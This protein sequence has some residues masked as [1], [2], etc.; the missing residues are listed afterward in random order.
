MAEKTLQSRVLMK[1]DTAENWAKGTNFSPKKGEVIVYNGNPPRIKVGDG[2]TNVNNLPFITYP[3]TQEQSDKLGT[4]EEG[5][6]KYILP[7]AS[8]T[9]GGVKTTSTVSSTSGLTATPIINGV[10][11]Y[12]DTTYTLSGL[13][14]VPTSRKI[15]GKAL[16]A[17]ITLSASDVGAAAKSDAEANASDITA[18]TTRVTTAESQILQKADSITLSVLETKVDGISVGGTNLLTQA[19]C[20]A[21][22]YYSESAAWRSKYGVILPANISNPVFQTSNL[23]GNGAFVVGET[24]TLSFTAKAEGTTNV[25]TDLYPDTI[26]GIFGNAKREVTTTPRKIVMTD[27]LTSSDNLG[28]VYLRFWRM[29]SEPK[30]AIQIWDIKLEKGNKA[31]DWSPAPEDLATADSLA[32]YLPLSGGTMTGVINVKTGTR[33][34][35]FHFAPSYDSSYAGTI[36]YDAGDN[37]KYGSSTSFYVRQYSV[38]TGSTSSYEASKFEDFRFPSTASGLTTSMNYTI[39]TT[40]NPPTASQVGALPLS[41]GTLTGTLTATALYASNG[42]VTG[43]HLVT[44]TNNYPEVYFKNAAGTTLADFYADTTTGAYS[45]IKLRVYADTDVKND[46]IFGTSGLFYAPILQGGSIYSSSNV[47]IQKQKA[48]ENY[49]FIGNTDDSTNIYMVINAQERGVYSRNSDG[50]REGYVFYSPNTTTDWIFN[51][52]AKS[53]TD[54]LPISLGGTGA[55]TAAGARTNLGIT[56]ANIGAAASSHT[57]SYLPLSGGTISGSL[58]VSGNITSNGYSV[59]TAG[60][61]VIYSST[62]PTGSAGMIWL[63]P[64]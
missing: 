48:N 39:F 36:V 53:L 22:E 5:A 31:T 8:S 12:K 17:D 7:T 29:P 58:A 57:H 44:K 50:T 28:D 64:V 26:G 56:P 35:E 19:S 52:K 6:N 37:N 38:T 60:G 9:L 30:F 3:F 18:L 62:Q 54:T 45:D 34:S 10:P 4:I 40:K 21:N 24:Y 32:K 59:Y 46:F 2:S 1:N 11:Y 55:T 33:Y 47:I 16:S 23:N 25:Y 27:V 41:G 49:V 51:G 61:N 15:N 13:G 63:K 14:G 20:K 42:N 43:D